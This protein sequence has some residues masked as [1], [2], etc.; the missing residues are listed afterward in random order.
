MLAETVY[1]LDVIV[2]VKCE[3]CKEVY[4]YQ[5]KLNTT[6][7]IPLSNIHERMADESV[8]E[9][10]TSEIRS[11]RLSCH[12]CPKCGYLQSWEHDALKR[13][14]GLVLT[15][16]FL[17]AYGCFFL[18][19]NPEERELH[20]FWHLAIVVVLT[21]LV[22]RL[23]RLLGRLYLRLHQARAGWPDPSSGHIGFSVVKDGE[24]GISPWELEE[25]KKGEDSGI[26]CFAGILIGTLAMSMPAWC[27]LYLIWLGVVALF[28]SWEHLPPNVEDRILF[29]SF[30]PAIVLGATSICAP[31]LWLRRRDRIEEGLMQLPE[32][33]ESTANALRRNGI[34]TIASLAASSPES[35][36]KIPGIGVKKANKLIRVASEF[37]RDES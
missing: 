18:L 3:A 36:S 32:V 25:S 9:Q 22:Y 8:A 31:I 35:L 7:D 21:I 33:G 5:R 26:G 15:G 17:S 10:F 1:W 28:P 24:T 2:H 20:W 13:I 4:H 11:P 29:L 37:S 14:L 30:I 16:C 23:G 12:G 19:S 34:R 27:L 6:R